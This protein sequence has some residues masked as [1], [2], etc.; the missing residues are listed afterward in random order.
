ME[1][2]ACQRQAN[3]YP[4]GNV[5]PEETFLEKGTFGGD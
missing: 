2:L 5:V 3:L 1:I 4:K